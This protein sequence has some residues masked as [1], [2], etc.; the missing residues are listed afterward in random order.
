MVKWDGDVWRWKWEWNRELKG[1]ALNEFEE[2]LGLYF[3][4]SRSMI[5]FG[6]F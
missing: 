1:T 2:M 5:E 4:R 6:G 3:P